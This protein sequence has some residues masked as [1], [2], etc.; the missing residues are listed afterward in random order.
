[1]QTQRVWDRLGPG[2]WDPLVQCLQLDKH[3][4]EQQ[5]TKKLWGTKNN[6]VHAQLG[7]IMNNRIQNRPKPHPAPPRGYLG[8]LIHPSG[9]TPGPTPS[10]TPLRES[11]HTPSASKQGNLLLVF[12]PPAPP[13]CIKGP[14][15]ALPE[16]LIWPLT[17]F[18]WLRKPRT[19]VGSKLIISVLVLSFGDGAWV[20]WYHFGLIVL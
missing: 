6:C 19:L 18:Y 5:N 12:A 17:N 10:L 16:F 3:F 7:Q 11:A 14:S 4:L 2:T 1:M 8:H 9:L 20:L 15:K 13:H